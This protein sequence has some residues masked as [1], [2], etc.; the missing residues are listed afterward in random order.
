MGRQR[1]TGQ[2]HQTVGEGKQYQRSRDIEATVN[3][4]DSKRCCHFS[5]KSKW[6]N[7]IDRIEHSKEQDRSDNIKIQMN[8]SRTF[9]IAGSTDTGDHGGNTGTDILSHDNGN[10]C[11]KAYRSSHAQCLQNTY[12]CGRRLDHRCENES[13]Q[14]TEY[15]ILELDQQ[16][17]KL[18]YLCQ[19]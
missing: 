5:Q 12:G 11:A 14:H 16:I 1:Q 4:C 10:C 17:G 3:Y 7:G 13:C 18:R 6:M 8:Q 2:L 19:R 9:C 15:G